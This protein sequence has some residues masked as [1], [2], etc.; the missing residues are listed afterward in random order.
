MPFVCFYFCRVRRI[1]NTRK[2]KDKITAQPK[3]R[4][5]LALSTIFRGAMDTHLPVLSFERSPTARSAFRTLGSAKG[6]WRTNKD[7]LIGFKG[8]S[9]S[10]FVFV[11]IFFRGR[12]WN[13]FVGVVDFHGSF[14]VPSAF[15]EKNG[16]LSLGRSHGSLVSVIGFFSNEIVAG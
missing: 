8:V 7:R 4:I 6:T 14:C 9:F 12:D 10:C 11:F 3:L 15:A 13:P 5:F 1:S 16:H 2:R